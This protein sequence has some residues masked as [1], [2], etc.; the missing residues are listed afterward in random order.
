V[1]FKATL[2]QIINQTNDTYS[3]R[4]PKPKELTYKPG[5]YMLVNLK[6]EG[7]DLIHPLSFSSSPTENHIEFTKKLS[8]SPFST[9]LAALKLNYQIRIDAPYGQFTFMGE[10]PKICLVAGGIGITPFRSIAKY[11]T[12]K[13]LKVD[14]NLLYCCR[15]ET[16]IAFRE[17]LNQM[18]NQNPNLNITFILSEPSTSWKGQTGIISDEKIKTLVPDYKERVFFTCGPPGMILATKKIIE[19]LGLPSSQLRLEIFSGH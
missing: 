10:Q 12:D 8:T 6:P 3:F 4:F 17:D 18:Q 13:Q 7:N 11:A 9:A 16:Q 14:I 5:Q 19:D 15:D 1:K 2:Q